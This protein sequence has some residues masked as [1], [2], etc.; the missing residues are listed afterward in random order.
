MNEARNEENSN[1]IRSD[2]F[3]RSHVR[4]RFE[5]WKRMPLD[6]EADRCL[7]AVYH[8]HCICIVFKRA[9]DFMERKVLAGKQFCKNEKEHWLF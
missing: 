7:Y 9:N 2:Q 5:F 6:H 8:R 3:Y 4:D 1:S